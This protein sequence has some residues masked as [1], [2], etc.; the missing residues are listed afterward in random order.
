[1]NKSLFVITIILLGLFANSYQQAV[2]V[3]KTAKPAVSITKKAKVVLPSIKT[4]IQKAAA[5]LSV[6]FPILT[7]AVA[8]Q[9]TNIQKYLSTGVK[10]MKMLK[11]AQAKKDSK[12]I[13]RYTKLVKKYRKRIAIAKK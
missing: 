5:S 1:M 7:K 13:I 10:Y 3:K 2:A 11:S 12:N 8:D 6:V 4:I 9:A